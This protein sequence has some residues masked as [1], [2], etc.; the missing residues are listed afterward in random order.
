MPLPL[1]VA[2]IRNRAKTLSSPTGIHS[3]SSI[4]Q[5]SNTS[6]QRPIQV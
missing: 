5:F 3:G 6:F 2:Y 4:R 1:P